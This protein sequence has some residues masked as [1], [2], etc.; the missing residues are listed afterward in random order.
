MHTNHKYIVIAFLTLFACFSC[1]ESEEN[2]VPA[3]LSVE[4]VFAPLVTD[5]TSSSPI[6]LPDG[7]YHEITIINSEQEAADN[8]PSGTTESDTLYNNI[9]YTDNSLLSLKFR[10]FYKPN[11]IEYRIFKDHEGQVAIKQMLHVSDSLH[12]KGYFIMSNLITDKLSK[13]DKI[14]IEQSYF[15][16]QETEE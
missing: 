15:F 9:N 16:E 7:V 2:D 5:M 13:H 11:K 12:I 3:Q 8:L 4:H 10:S 6:H 14:S 1:A